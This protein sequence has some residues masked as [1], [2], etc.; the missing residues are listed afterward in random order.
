MMSEDI[1]LLDELKTKHNDIVRDALELKQELIHF[2]QKIK[3][4]VDETLLKSPLIITKSQRVPT[5]FDSEDMECYKL[6]PP[7]IPQVN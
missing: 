3:D 1:M 2:H 5:N 6:P 7:I 4:D